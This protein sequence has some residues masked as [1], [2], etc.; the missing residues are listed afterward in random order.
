MELQIPYRVCAEVQIWEVESRYWEDT[1]GAVQLEAGEHNRSRNVPRS[2]T[3]AS[4]NT[5]EDERI[6]VGFLK[7]KSTL[8]IF[9]RHANLKQSMGIEVSGAEGTM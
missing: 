8:L 2:R 5:A 1:E 6:Q 3:Y 7:G 4:G 9:E